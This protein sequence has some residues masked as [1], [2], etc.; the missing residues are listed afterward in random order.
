M[1]K[2]W[3]A[4]TNQE[5][6]HIIKHHSIYALNSENKFNQLTKGDKIVIYLIPKQLSGLFFISN[7]N[8]KTKVRFKGKEY[9]Y[10]FDIK[11]IKILSEPILVCNKQSKGIIVENLSIFKNIK[12]KK[13]GTVLM[14]SSIIEITERD[15]DLIK[16]E[17]QES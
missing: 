4:L 15:Y 1:T 3:L 13:W 5:N 16:N 2:Y 6:W 12:G 7:F 9:K 11:P 14:G 10:Y 8:S 17:I